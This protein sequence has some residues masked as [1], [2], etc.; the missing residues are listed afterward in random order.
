MNRLRVRLT[1]AFILI[2]LIGVGSVVLLVDWSA[3]NEFR[4]YVVRQG[5]MAQN[6]LADQLAAFYQQ[7]GGWQ[8]VE[9]ILS[10]FQ[11]GGALVPSVRRGPGPDTGGGRGR[12]VGGAGGMGRGGGPL[13][14]LAD[15]NGR[16]VYD[17]RGIGANQTLSSADRANSIPIQSN[18]STIGYLLAISPGAGALQP[19]AQAFLDELRST[20]LLAGLVAGLAGIVLGVVISRNL[21]APLASLAQAARAVAARQLDRR[22]PVKGADEIADVSRAFNEMAEELQASDTA[23]RNMVADIAHELRTPLTV[24][25]GNLRAMLDGVYP[26]DKSEVA[27]LYDETRLLNRLVDDLRELALAD[28]GQLSL[29]LQTI[30]LSP[31]LKN[32][33]GQFA[34][35]AEEK[36]VE[37]SVKANRELPAVRGDPDRVAQVLRNLIANALRHTP[38]RGCIIIQAEAEPAG[39]LVRISVRDTG[40]GIGPEDTPHI[41]ER[42]Y[43]ADRSRASGMGS[44]G[45]GLAI[46]KAWVEAMGGQ[47]GVESELGK[48]SVFWLDLPIAETVRATPSFSH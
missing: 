23:R 16:I 12:G 14:V 18:G 37:L 2:T 48:G 29:G 17:E 7:H 30:E 11:P 44:S 47:I 3:G 33:A 45:L 36:Q 5:M 9:S 34:I 38:G 46:A 1:L 19:A 13:L 6:G 8:G 42:F 24:M 41:F 10:G 28:A 21:A 26:L 40:E 32:V 25:Q 35:P 22:V 43:R 27:T 20:L 15:A 4:Q 39:G 31:L